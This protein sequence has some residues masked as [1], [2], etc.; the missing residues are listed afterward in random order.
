MDLQKTAL[1]NLLIN[2]MLQGKFATFFS[3]FQLLS[4]TQCP[5]ALWS[6]EKVTAQQQQ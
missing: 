3:C 4:H 5:S 2:V 1:L 6:L